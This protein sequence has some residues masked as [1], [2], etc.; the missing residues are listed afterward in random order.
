MISHNRYFA[1]LAARAGARITDQTRAGA[2]GI[3][4]DVGAHAVTSGSPLA[5]DPLPKGPHGPAPL[6][7]RVGAAD[8][9]PALSPIA[10]PTGSQPSVV[11]S[12]HPRRKDATTLRAAPGGYSPRGSGAGSTRRQE[13]VQLK[14]TGSAAIPSK[15]EGPGVLS[16]RA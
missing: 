7:S 2:I 9:G 1:Q 8:T 11:S 6:N 13:P 10:S 4:T 15:E 14:R 3:P 16:A 5:R 12:P